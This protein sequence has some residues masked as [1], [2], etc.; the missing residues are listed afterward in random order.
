MKIVY[1]VNWSLNYPVYEERMQA[2]AAACIVHFHSQEPL[3][4]LV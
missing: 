2:I 4:S 1:D 3:F